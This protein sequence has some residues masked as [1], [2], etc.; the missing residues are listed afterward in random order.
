MRGITRED[1]YPEMVYDDEDYWAR[2]EKK[3]VKERRVRFKKSGELV[4]FISAREH[5]VKI[6]ITQNLAGRLSSLR[7]ASPV[8]LEVLHVIH[9][10][11]PNLERKIHEDLKHLRFHGEWF[12]NCAEIISYIGGLNAS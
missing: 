1:I 10:R 8:P 11:G 3:R 6:G 4:Y 2:L 5:G 12:R 9:G 7:S